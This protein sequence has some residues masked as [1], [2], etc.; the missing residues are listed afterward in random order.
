MIYLITICFMT[1]I[2][3]ASLPFKANIT[4]N[5]KAGIYL[6]SYISS[7]SAPSCSPVSP[8]L[9]FLSLS[10]LHSLNNICRKG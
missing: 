10:F 7:T 1:I 8:P 5:G 6:S 4:S 2:V 9:T 3:D